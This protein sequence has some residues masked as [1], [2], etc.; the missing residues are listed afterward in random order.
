MKTMWSTASPTLAIALIL[1]LEAQ[2][3]DVRTISLDEAVKIAFE[4]SNEVQSAAIAVAQSDVSVSER[5][6]DFLPSLTL[7]GSRTE[8]YG[9]YFS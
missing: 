4:Q 1:P 3:Q 6:M 8:N 9:R 7:T 5:Q 2:A